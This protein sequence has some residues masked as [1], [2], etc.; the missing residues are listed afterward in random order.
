MSII[1][2]ILV[3]WTE[4]ENEIVKKGHT[5]KQFIGICIHVPIL[6]MR[7]FEIVG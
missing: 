6:K 5:I 3:I 2:C 1:I 7:R 4:K